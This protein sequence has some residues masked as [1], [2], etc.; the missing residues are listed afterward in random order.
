LFIVQPFQ[1]DSDIRSALGFMSLASRWGDHLFPGITVLTRDL[2][3][4]QA[5]HQIATEMRAWE[6]DHR[7][8]FRRRIRESPDS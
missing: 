7:A 8:A 5:M 2:Y 1:K 6:P 3:A 4:V